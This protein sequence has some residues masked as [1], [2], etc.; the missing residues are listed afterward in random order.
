MIKRLITKKRKM[1][2]SASYFFTLH[3]FI[4]KLGDPVEFSVR[5]LGNRLWYSVNVLYQFNTTSYYDG[6]SF[7][8]AFDFYVELANALYGITFAEKITKEKLTL[9]DKAK[10]LLNETAENK[11]RNQHT[12]YFKK[13]LFLGL[14]LIFNTSSNQLIVCMLLNTF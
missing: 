5:I 12:L 2:K 1:R 10:K 4:S 7:E 3:S 11:Y 13:P 6:N 8:T 14:S 9:L